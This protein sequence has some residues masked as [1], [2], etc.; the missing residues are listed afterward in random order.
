MRLALFAVS[1]LA[2]ACTASLP[3]AAPAP[4]VPFNAQ[5][6]AWVNTPGT[7]TVEGQ[8][9]MKTRGGDVKYGAGEDVWLIPN[10]AHSFDWY[11]RLT[12][13]YGDSQ[14]KKMDPQLAALVRKTVAGGD[15]RFRFESVPAGPYLIL[16]SVTWLAG[17]S[18]QGGF[19]GTTAQAEN[20]KTV[21]IIVTR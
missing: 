4:L 20:G 12:S 1:I 8:A 14:V 3:P 15:G 17:R 18:Q 7:A 2:T 16:T 19:V 13:R 9:F 21:N 11:S 10:S 5:E 6:V